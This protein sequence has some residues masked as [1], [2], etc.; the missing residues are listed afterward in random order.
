MHDALASC[1][2]TQ[3]FSAE[4]Q[5][6]KVVHR[7]SCGTARGVAR[8]GAC[9][10]ARGTADGIVDGFAR[11]VSHANA[12]ENYLR[13]AHLPQTLEL[14]IDVLLKSWWVEVAV[15]LKPRAHSSF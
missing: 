3:I 15:T 8:A 2:C 1:K 9:G 10:I 5:L 6:G 11:G 4:L 12:R 13:T 14:E 7:T